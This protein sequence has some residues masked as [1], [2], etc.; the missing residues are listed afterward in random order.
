[1]H[2]AHKGEERTLDA[3]ELELQSIVSC[4]VG[5]L[6]RASALKH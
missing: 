5:A 2:G 6:A 4:H 1:M 3:L